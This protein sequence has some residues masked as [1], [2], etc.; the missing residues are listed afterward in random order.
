MAAHTGR[1]A[2]AYR[3]ID[4]MVRQNADARR[5]HRWLIHPLAAGSD[6]LFVAIA[7]LLAY[8]LRYSLELGGEIARYSDRSLGFFTDKIIAL[9]VVTVIIFQIRGLYSLPRWAGFLDEA[10]RVASG[11]TIAMAL[12]I[13]Y[14]FLQRFYPSRL[15]FIYAWVLMIGLLLAKRLATQLIR[16]MLWKRGIGV[17]RVLVAGAGQASQRIMQYILNQPQLGFRVI[18]FVDGFPMADDWGIATEHR[19]ER[20][21]YLGSLDDVET[22]VAKQQIDQVIIAL[23]QTEHDAVLGIIE[24]CRE[25]EVAFTL[26]PD[27]FE[28]ALDQVMINEVAG[29]PLIEIKEARIRGWNY[30]VK[31]AM[32]ML[33]STLILLIC[34]PIMLA[35]AIAIKL[36]SPGPVLF[37]HERVGK[38]GERFTLYKF[39]SMCQDA[40]RQK[41]ALQQ[42][43]NTTLLFKMRNDPRVTRVGRFLRRTSLDELPQFFNILNGDMSFVG[44]RPQVP[45]EV[46]A[47]S[48]WHYQRL[49][50]TP[51]LTGLW[52][53]N[54]R[55]DLSFDEMVK[56]DL[57][58]AEH[59]SPWLDIKLTLR[60][61]PA[62]IRRRGAY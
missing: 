3:R 47:Y 36:D 56:L 29:L 28:L 59:W 14:N 49:L 10:S 38:N 54:G 30:G 37:H 53:V 1:D 51:G 41:E 5:Q 20:P 24:K 13:L 22:I 27:L 52:Q 35:I 16:R 45:S 58:Y 17:D 19:V 57:Y 6:M 44:P 42:A 8:W 31:R 9:A 2:T 21:D 39:R 15:V 43:A 11:C 48:D 34:S 61:I 62:V 40:E 23:P 12:I 7:F 50:V 25:I 46:A 4:A 33:I 60:T 26:V 32:D 18:G 55:S